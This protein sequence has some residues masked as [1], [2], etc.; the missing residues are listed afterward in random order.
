MLDLAASTSQMGR[1]ETGAMTSTQ[2]LTALADVSGRSAAPAGGPTCV[3]GMPCTARQGQEEPWHPASA[4]RPTRIRLQATRNRLPSGPQEGQRPI[5]RGVPPRLPG[6][7][8]LSVFGGLCARRVPTTR[9]AC[10]SIGS[11]RAGAWMISCAR[12]HH[13]DIGPHPPMRRSHRTAARH[14]P[15]FASPGALV[16]RL[17]RCVGAP[18][19]RR[20]DEERSGGGS[21]DR[22]RHDRCT[23]GDIGTKG[24]ADAQQGR[25]AAPN[26]R[27]IM[28]RQGSGG[29]EGPHAC[30]VR[31]G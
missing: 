25:Q 26:E 5:R 3:R 24:C 20:L 8:G 7:V 9:H 10:R 18:S 12:S 31:T 2:N 11:P 19:V 6:N 14:P 23:L 4:A 28:T 17:E 22:I 13:R 16:R 29:L 1:F 27:P 15:A 21:R 30:L